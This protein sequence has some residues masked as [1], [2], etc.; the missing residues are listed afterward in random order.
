MTYCECQLK[1]RLEKEVREQLKPG[2][3]AVLDVIPQEVMRVM[4]IAMGKEGRV[5]WKAVYSE[6]RREKGGNGR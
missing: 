4:N 6:W 1:G 3:W 5:V 2:L